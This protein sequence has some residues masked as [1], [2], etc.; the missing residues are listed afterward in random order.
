M[1]RGGCAICVYRRSN[2]HARFCYYVHRL[3]TK[4]QQRAGIRSEKRPAD[5]L[6]SMHEIWKE[7]VW[8]QFGAAIDM[9]ANAIRECPDDVWGDQTAEPQYWAL[10]F[11]TLFWLDLYL[12]GT[13]EGYHPPEPF[14]LE[15]MDPAGVLPPRV[16]TREELMTFLLACR[17]RCKAIIEEMDGESAKR[18]CHFGKRVQPFGELL[19]YNMRHVQHHAAQLNLLLRQRTNSA[20]LWVGRALA[21]P[22]GLED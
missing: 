6:L 10:A 22:R 7:A 11:H 1:C 19:I 2:E 5:D 18:L 17:S 4:I 3:A 8:Q 12:G 13:S 15:E 14:G 20:P 16:Y 9:L 21:E